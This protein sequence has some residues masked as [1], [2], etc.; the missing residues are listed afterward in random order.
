MSGAQQE[1]TQLASRLAEE[2]PAA[3]QN[4]TMELRPLRLDLLGA[5]YEPLLL[6]AVLAPLILVLGAINVAG[7]V[8]AIVEGA[9]GRW[10]LESALGARVLQV[11]VPSA[12][13]FTTLWITGAVFSALLTELLLRFLRPLAAQFLP[14]GAALMWDTTTTIFFAGGALAMAAVAAVLG[15]HLVLDAHQHPEAVLTGEGTR[16]HVGLGRLRHGIV[17]G[18]LA[19]ASFVVFLGIWLLANYARLVWWESD[20][21][22]LDLLQWRYRSKSSDL[23]RPWA[24][25]WSTMDASPRRNG[26]PRRSGRVCNHRDAP[27][28]VEGR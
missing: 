13:T 19:V 2:H 27:A 17:G 11:L 25:Y 4:W 28:S 1:L 16:H 5:A 9:R 10:Q 8:A 22:R 12:R 20:T 21:I 3:N 6:V 23:A 7:A 14:F 24:S 18:Q 15:T 26:R